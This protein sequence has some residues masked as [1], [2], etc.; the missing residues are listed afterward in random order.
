MIYRPKT[1]KIGFLAVLGMVAGAFGAAAME[2]DTVYYGTELVDD[3][4]WC[5]SSVLPASKVSD[6]RPSN[7][8]GWDDNLD[9]AWCEGASGPGHGEWFEFRTRPGTTIKTMEIYNGYQ[10]SQKSFYDNAR[11]ADVNIVTDSGLKIFV[12]LKDQMG[13]QVITLQNWHDVKRIRVTIGN[14]YRG[15]KYQDLCIS[16]FGINFEEIREYE[17][18][19]LQKETQ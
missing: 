5:A 3:V 13:R 18:Q 19:Q 2:C 12:P 9:K 16:A 7:L 6:Y 11:A 17:W 10:K 14:V 8:D 1:F 15:R 4:T